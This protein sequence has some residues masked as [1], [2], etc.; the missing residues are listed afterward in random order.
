MGNFTPGDDSLEIFLKRIDTVWHRN[1]DL[2]LLNDTSI[3]PIKKTEKFTIEDIEA[4]SAN[5]KALD[6]FLHAKDTMVEPSCREK[7]CILFA[8][9]NKSTQIMHLYIGG[10]LLDSFKVSTG[11]I[12]RETPDLNFRPRGPLLKKYT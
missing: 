2:M 5:V 12:G 11:I 9:I 7:D 6:S 8:D 10:E 4:I 3:K 1:L